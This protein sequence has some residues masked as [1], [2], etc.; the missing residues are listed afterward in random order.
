MAMMNLWELN[1]RVDDFLRSLDSGDGELTAQQI[2]DHESLQGDVDNAI[3]QL[4]RVTRNLNAESTILRGEGTALINR[5][6]V[7]E[8]QRDRFKEALHMLMTKLQ[9]QKRKVGVFDVSIRKNS[10]FS[11][12]VDPLVLDLSDL[13]KV[14]ESYP[15][16]V[17]T[18]L[19][20]SRSA[21]LDMAEKDRPAGITVT[22]G[23]HVH[24]TE[25]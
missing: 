20:F 6:R 10:V 4:V 24:I 23:T 8:G 7:K 19:T 11:V 22:Q 18:E 2:V 17:K 15:S 16:L 14:A 3:E 1:N 9:I 5:A 21:V 12:I 13:A 25:R